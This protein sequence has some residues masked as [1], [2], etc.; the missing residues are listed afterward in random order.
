MH[1]CYC[2]H[3]CWINSFS[4]WV[5]ITMWHYAHI[6]TKSWSSRYYIKSQYY[7]SSL[8]CIN[9]IYN[10]RNIY[11]GK[12]Y[13]PTAI[14]IINPTGNF[15]LQQFLNLFE[16]ENGWQYWPRL[17]WLN[18]LSI[19]SLDL[20]LF[21]LYAPLTTWIPNRSVVQLLQEIFSN[22]KLKSLLNHKRLRVSSFC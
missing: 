8:Y 13:L 10:I 21:K 9:S 6:L 4:V 22:V 20:I 5:S 19:N 18:Y 17:M 11:C 2:S 7:V 12:S 3:I 14:L 16:L 15:F 1:G